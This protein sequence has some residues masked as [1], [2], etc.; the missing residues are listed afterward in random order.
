MK[1][2]PAF[3]RKAP[4]KVFASILLGGL[5]GI[6]YSLLIPLVLNVLR[7]GDR[8][9]DT[10]ESANAYFLGFEIANYTFALVF[11]AV[12]VFILFARTLSQV[13]LTRVAVDVASDLRQTMYERIV[14]APLPALESIGPSRL[15]A[16]LTSDV[17]RIVA[18]AR[19][20]PDLLINMVTLVGMLGF[21]LFL[22]ADVFWFVM[23]CIAFGVVSYQLPMFVGRRYFRRARQGVDDL[24]ESIRGLIHGIKELKL[25]DAKRRAYFDSVLLA[26][27]R[28]VLRDEKTGHTIVRA[29]MNYGDLLSFFVIGSITFV[30]VNYRAITNAELVG[31]IMALLYVTGPVAVLL[32][33]IPQLSVARVSLQRVTQLFADIP[34]ENIDWKTPQRRAWRTLRLDGVSYRH[35]A[36][37]GGAGFGIGPVDLELSRGEITFIVGGNG[38]GKSTLSKLLTLHYRPESG[39]IRFDDCGVGPDNIGDWRESVAAIYSD[40]YLFDRLLVRPDA[41]TEKAVRHY[42]EVLKLDGKVSYADGR[43]STLALSDGQ[44]RRLALLVAF[45]EDRDLYLFDEWAADQDPTFKNVFYNEILPALRDK[46]KAVVAI[47]HD[48]RYFHVA[49]KVIVMEEGRVARIERPGDVRAPRAQPRGDVF[50]MAEDAA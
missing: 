20:L 18:G 6:A 16:A 37:D 48:D 28:Q 35:R 9:L 22:N 8:R 36:R 34:R 1:L 47:T 31:V 2:F 46:G 23:G 30:F 39:E 25:G 40:Y 3:S 41:A 11:C 43:F 49:D 14:R 21:L 17:P 24:Q 15:I 12:C 19:M 5:A 29:A 7:E 44:R 33:F 10:V 38:S 32:N 4:N 13:M 27:E 45:V 26:H 42:L 50:A